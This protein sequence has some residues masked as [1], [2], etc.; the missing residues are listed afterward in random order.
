MRPLFLVPLLLLAGCG[1]PFDRDYRQTQSNAFRGTLNHSEL[2]QPKPGSPSSL[3]MAISPKP[4]PST[5]LLEETRFD[6][7]R[8]VA[9]YWSHG[10]RRAALA[11][12]RTSRFNQD[13]LAVP[14]LE[15][16]YYDRRDY[17]YPPM[18]G[19]REALAPGCR[20]V[21]P[22]HPG[23]LPGHLCRSPGGAWILTRDE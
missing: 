21:A 9:L 14:T 5:T 6:Q 7:D 23:G 11:P 20:Q 10:D 2:A 12:D 13:N 22:I 4:T 17:R 15:L 16:P 8:A 1:D 3:I 19:N 18:H